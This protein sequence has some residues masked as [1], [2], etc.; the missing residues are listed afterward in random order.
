M[1][2][3][4]KLNEYRK[5]KLY[6]I[7]LAIVSGLATG[8]S[9]LRPELFSNNREKYETIASCAGLTI[10]GVGGAVYIGDRGNWLKD[11]GK[12]NKWNPDFRI[13][14]IKF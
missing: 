2:W 3:N 4:T 5:Y 12:K 10:L 8:S 6:C 13:T 1:E 7:A 14:L 11:I 9:I